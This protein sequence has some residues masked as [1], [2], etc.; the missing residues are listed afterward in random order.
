[1]AAINRAAGEIAREAF[2]SKRGFVLGDSGPFGGL[3]APYGDMAESRVEDAFFEQAEALVSGGVDAIIVETQTALEELGIGIRAAK[4][5]GAPCVIGSMAFDKMLASDDVRTMMGTSPEQAAVFMVEEGA[6]IIALNC[7]TGVDMALA[8]DSVKL[9]RETCELPVMAQPNAGLP[10]VENMKVVYQGNTGRNGGRCDRTARRGRADHRWLLR[11]HTGPQSRN[12]ERFWSMRIELAPENQDA[13]KLLPESKDD[14]SGIGINYA[15]AYI[16]PF[17][18]ILDDGRKVACKRRGL[19]LT[20]KIGDKSGKGLMRR[21][22]NGPDVKTILREA[23][24]EA[25]TDA[26][27]VFAVEDGMMILTET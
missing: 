24:N 11:K 12:S 23:L 2:G 13:D 16:K 14:G 4:A 1:M 21:L 22:A 3:L 17:K 9:Y 26:G 10:V 6:D 18:K 27:V 8:A 15:D 20:L 7:G 19:E 25:A 5:A